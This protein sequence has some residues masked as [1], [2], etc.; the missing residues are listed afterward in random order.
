MTL[1]DTGLPQ[2]KIARH[3]KEKCEEFYAKGDVFSNDKNV[4]IVT[5]FKP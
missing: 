2:D 3:I 5:I 1:R 4:R